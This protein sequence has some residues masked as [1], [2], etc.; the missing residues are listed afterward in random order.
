[1]PLLVK[2][3][4]KEHNYNNYNHNLFYDY[5]YTQTSNL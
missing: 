5:M 1:M 3:M 2:H 4:D